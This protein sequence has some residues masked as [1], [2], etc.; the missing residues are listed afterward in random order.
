LD[1]AGLTIEYGQRVALVGPNGSGKTTL[2][3]AILNHADWEHPDIDVTEGPFHIAGRL[4]T[5]ASAKIG[6][7]SQI[8]QHALDEHATLID[9]FMRVSDLRYQPA[10]EMLHRFLFHRDDLAREIGTLSGGEKSRLQLARLV[11][12]QVNFL[13][14]DEPTNHLDIQ[15]CEQLEE[16]L[17]EFE[18]TLLV[19]SHDRYFLDKLVNRV[20]E[21]KD[22][23]LIP[24]K[25]TFADW[26]QEK[27]AEVSGTEN[28]S[29]KRQRGLGSEGPSMKSQSDAAANTKQQREDQK[30][31]QR[32]Q[33]RLRTQ[34]KQ[35]EARIEKLEA[36]QKE[37]ET[38]LAEAFAQ[39]GAEE[40][41]ELA[42]SFDQVRAEIAGLYKQWEELA[43]AVEV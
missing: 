7:Y 38:K 23:Q 35:L 40:A 16:M 27:H 11:H 31:K 20:V 25:G 22:Q 42:D 39:G 30:A 28:R 10:T 8:H 37:L 41:R 6:D 14:L 24:F 15:A 33:H 29:P 5:G 36:R 3:K 12:E 21:L 26:W 1:A 4:R 34:L 43:P 18:G 19:I 32:E 17:D 2:F 9:W 13:M